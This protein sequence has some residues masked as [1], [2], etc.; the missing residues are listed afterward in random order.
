MSLFNLIKSYIYSPDDFIQ[1]ENEN[2]NENEN[3]EPSVPVELTMNEVILQISRL[4]KGQSWDLHNVN[5]RTLIGYLHG[6]GSIDLFSMSKNENEDDNENKNNPVI[7]L[8][9]T[10][11]NQGDSVF[12]IVGHDHEQYCEISTLVLTG[13]L[14]NTQLKVVIDFNKSNYH[15]DNAIAICTIYGHHQSNRDV[16]VHSKFELH[17]QYW[18]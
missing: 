2:E 11:I 14:G 15:N 10:T 16:D 18:L 8:P 13:L 17:S 3:E 9:T 12:T 1:T 7:Y 6:D 4:R 5:D